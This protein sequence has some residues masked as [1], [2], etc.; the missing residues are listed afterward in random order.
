MPESIV[1][2]TLPSPFRHRTQYDAFSGAKVF[3]IENTKV[4]DLKTKRKKKI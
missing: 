1:L 4:K 3:K 2:R